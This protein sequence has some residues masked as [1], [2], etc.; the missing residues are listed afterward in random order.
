MK[1]T[2]AES[3]V[4]VLG[5]EEANSNSLIYPGL[6]FFGKPLSFFHHGGSF[7]TPFGKADGYP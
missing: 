5:V 6:S 2:K 1:A 3:P 4:L 7:F